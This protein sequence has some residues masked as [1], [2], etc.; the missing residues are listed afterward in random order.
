M[1]NHTFVW[2]IRS[3]GLNGVEEVTAGKNRLSHSPLPTLPKGQTNRF[4][5][6]L[7]HLS[8]LMVM[9]LP[10][11][12]L[13]GS[14]LVDSWLPCKDPARLKG[15]EKGLDHVPAFAKASNNQIWPCIVEKV[16]CAPFFVLTDFFRKGNPSPHSLYP[17]FYSHQD[18]SV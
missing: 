8:P 13:T 5:R 17:G 9:P 12:F 3:V 11:S 6:Q 15:K 18:C 7:V 2:A 14:V 10:F 4:D 1:K 16:R